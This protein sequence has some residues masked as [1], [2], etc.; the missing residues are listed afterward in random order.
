[1]FFLINYFSH[2][3]GDVRTTDR[4]S[5]GRSNRT[6]FYKGRN[7]LRSGILVL[8]LRIVKL[9]NNMRDF[10]SYPTVY[11]HAFNLSQ[12][13]MGAVPITT[14]AKLQQGRCNSNHGGN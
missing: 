8:C 1:M 2:P 5:C 14:S 13:H 11:S 3:P 6:A 10:I 12:T 9:R 7:Y 4:Y